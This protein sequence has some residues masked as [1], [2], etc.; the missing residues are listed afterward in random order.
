MLIDGKKIAEKLN[1]E[2]AQHVETLKKNGITPTLG[3]I[4]VGNNPASATYVHK[5]EQAA[6]K[7]GIGFKLYHFPENISESELLAALD[8]IQTKKEV[9]GLII[10]IPLPEHLYT[11]TILNA[12]HAELDVDCLTAENMGKLF[13]GSH[14]IAPPTPSAVISILEDLD[15]R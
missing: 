1:A 9:T 14:S 5:K 10:Q 11:L 6:K 3:V 7:I 4:L 2:T 13:L 15:E 8:E 12:L